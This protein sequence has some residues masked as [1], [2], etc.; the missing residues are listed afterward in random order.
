M[1]PRS[2]PFGPVQSRVDDAFAIARRLLRTLKFSASFGLGV[3]SVW[4]TGYAM[5]GIAFIG[6]R[7]P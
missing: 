1:A 3:T 4:R 2:D 5:P 6:V 7:I